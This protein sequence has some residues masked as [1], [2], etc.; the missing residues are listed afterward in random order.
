MAATYRYFGI[1][2]GLL[3][4]SVQDYLIRSIRSTYFLSWGSA[5]SASAPSYC[6]DG[7]LALRMLVPLVLGWCSLV[8]SVFSSASLPTWV[9]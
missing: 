9:S 3:D 5:S 1:E 4:L 2:I 7:S 6:I 8:W